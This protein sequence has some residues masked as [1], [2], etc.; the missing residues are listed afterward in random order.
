MKCRRALQEFFEFGFKR[1]AQTDYCTLNM[2]ISYAYQFNDR[3]IC[4]NQNSIVYA[5]VHREYKYRVNNVGLI[6]YTQIFS[7]VP[8]CTEKCTHANRAVE[9]KT[10]AMSC[11]WTA[12]N[13]PTEHSSIT[14]SIYRLLVAPVKMSLSSISWRFGWT[15]FICWLNL[16]NADLVAYP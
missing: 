8:V 11:G 2:W 5:F 12:F 13:F 14:C 4:E 6:Y 10:L 3:F 1:N 9:D 15:K 7:R 16:A